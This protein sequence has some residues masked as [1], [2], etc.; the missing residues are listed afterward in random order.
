MLW[1][2]KFSLSYIHVRLTVKGLLQNLH[3]LS[4]CKRNIVVFRTGLSLLCKRLLV[5]S[6]CICVSWLWP[7]A[8]TTSI[9]NW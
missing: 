1:S 7:D 3:L 8:L 6:W 5:F 2:P 9:T 4:G